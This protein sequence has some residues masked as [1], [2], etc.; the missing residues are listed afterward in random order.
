M[1]ELQVHGGGGL[2]LQWRWCVLMTCDD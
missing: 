2:D 1:T